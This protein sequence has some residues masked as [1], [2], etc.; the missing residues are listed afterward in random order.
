MFVYAGLSWQILGAVQVEWLR[1]KLGAEDVQAG[2]SRMAARGMAEAKE[3]WLQGLSEEV[4]EAAR[5]GDDVCIFI[6][7]RDVDA[8]VGVFLDLLDGGTT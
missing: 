4:V 7:P 8:A 2:W 1:E 3:S 5:D 6:L